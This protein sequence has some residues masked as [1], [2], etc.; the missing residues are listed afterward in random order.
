M[1]TSPITI[2]VNGID[3]TRSLNV[4]CGK[5]AECL[6]S[7]QNDYMVRM[8]EEFMRSSSAC[9]VTLTYAPENVP[10]FEI[11]GKKYLT[12]WKKDVQDWLKR[13]RT[14][15][16]RKYGEK[17]VFKYFLC[18]EYGPK[19]HRPHYHCI[20]WNLTNDDLKDAL[21]DWRERFGYY[22]IKDINRSPESFEKSARY[23]SKYACKGLFEDPFRVEWE[24]MQVLSVV[25]EASRSYLRFPDEVVSRL[26]Y[27]SNIPKIRNI[28]IS[29]YSYPVFESLLRRGCQA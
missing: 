16:E 6:K 13:F 17:P 26:F 7:K 19:T 5:C 11:K 15:Y 21:L 4:P 12:V 8:Y 1:C 27:L 14:N 29:D 22:L 23:V 18:S 3:G 28:D 9:M 25:F 20:F 24:S 10:Y 2:R